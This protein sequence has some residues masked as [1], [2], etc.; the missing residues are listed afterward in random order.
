MP[1]AYSSFAVIDVSLTGHHDCR[2]FVETL[3]GQAIFSVD[4]FQVFDLLKSSFL[5]ARSFT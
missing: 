2:C 3:C 5:L 1:W 4:T